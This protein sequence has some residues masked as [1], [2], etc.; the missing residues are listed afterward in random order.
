MSELHVTNSL[1]RQKERFEPLHP[2][3]VGM[4]VCGPTVYGEGHLGHARSAVTFDIV[5]RWLKHLGYRVR[6]V[7][8]ITDVGH[9]QGD[10][11]EGE[12]KIQK[13]ARL[14]QQEPM[15]IAQHYTNRYHD[16]MDRMNCLRPSI[17]P[18]ASGHIPE[19]I[20]MI[21]AIVA[22]GYAYVSNGSVYFDVRKYRQDFPYGKLSGRENPDDNQVGSR[23][24]DGQQEKRDAN[25]FALWKR[26]EP[27]HLMRWN[28]PWGVG[29]PGWHIECS[30][31]SAKY[32]GTPFDI[33]GG[34]LDLLFP[35]HEAE[36]AQN[37]AC[38]H[39]HDHWGNNSAKYW[40]HNNLITIGGQKMGKSLGNFI[41]LQQFFDGEHKLLSQPYSP[42]AIRFFIL[43]SHYRSTLDFSDEALQASE[44]GLKRLL[45]SI[46]SIE[47]IPAL[48][49]SNDVGDD[50]LFDW[51]ITPEQNPDLS[52]P[53]V[54]NLSYGQFID[55][56][57]TVLTAY[58]N[59]DFNTAKTLA[60]LF[61]ASGFAQILLKEQVVLSEER[62]TRF[63]KT[64]QTFAYDI[65]G[66]LPEDGSNGH[67]SALDASLNLLIQLRQDARKAKNFAVSDQIRD[68]LLA[69]GIQLKDGPQGTSWELA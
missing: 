28:S 35:H 54:L 19:Q 59:D 20:E 12:D 58:M 50:H 48:N 3:F 43:Q 30:A 27:T 6:Y 67:G 29:F 45:N 49:D 15:E 5:F 7:R 63:I 36:M 25:D 57:E 24:L 47:R 8:N 68:Q 66:L 56:L 41:T 62:K 4:Y 31:M 37:N 13:Q 51:M 14:E 69:A 42:M 16:V 11:D 33:H 2:P 34:G 32:L 65:L 23:E 53:T 60:M 9:L 17:E 55:T 52:R 64:V 38:G 61:E 44:K 40:L 21:E 26:A 18:H 46:K 1:S 22:A 39:D 10:A